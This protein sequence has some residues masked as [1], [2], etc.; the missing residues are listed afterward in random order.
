ML[1]TNSK[2]HGARSVDLYFIRRVYS[3]YILRKC[4]AKFNDELKTINVLNTHYLKFE[5]F[6]EETVSSGNKR[7]IRFRLSLF[8]LCQIG[9]NLTTRTVFY[10]LL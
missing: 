1:F 3:V 8:I 7:N 5:L 9:G 4:Y 2:K 10:L 6:L